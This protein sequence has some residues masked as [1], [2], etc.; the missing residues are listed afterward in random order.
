MHLLKLV[1]FLLLLKKPFL[2]IVTLLA[3]LPELSLEP[4]DLFLML[5]FL[6]L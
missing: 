2:V 3:C 4:V 1:H 6:V 5:S